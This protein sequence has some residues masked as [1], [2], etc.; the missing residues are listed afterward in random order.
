MEGSTLASDRHGQRLLAAPVWI[1]AF[2]VP[3]SLWLLGGAAVAHCDYCGI[4]FSGGSI[5]RGDYRFCNGVCANKGAVLTLL[6]SCSA[7]KIDKYISS[8]HSG[9]CPRCGARA[10][11]D[12]HQ[13]HRVYSV[14]VHTHWETRTHF[15]C[16]KCGRTQQLKDLGYCVLRGWWGFPFGLVITPWQ[17]A[18]NII[19]IMRRSD[20]PSRDLQRI[21]KL[22]LAKKLSGGAR[23]RT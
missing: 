21:A 1:R 15:C 23:Q 19:G 7:E 5:K 12:V 4:Y 6:Y 14:L 20:R 16:R 11:V 10:N 22:D 2:L 9:P 18:R 8:V 17:M 13:S 3:S